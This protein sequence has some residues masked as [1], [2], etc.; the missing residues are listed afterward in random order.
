MGLALF[1]RLRVVVP[2]GNDAPACGS[3]F[4]G[5][6]SAGGG[7]RVPVQSVGP[8]AVAVDVGGV[9]ARDGP[10]ML[11]VLAQGR[12]SIQYAFDSAG[13]SCYRFERFGLR[14]RPARGRH[15]S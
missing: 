6:R 12:D 13:V 8:P 3:C 9:G 15:P 14:R 1:D 2:V 4:G 5:C 11:G 7:R 10:S